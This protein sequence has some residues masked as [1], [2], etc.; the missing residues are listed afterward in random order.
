[1]IHKVSLVLDVECLPGN[2][3][4]VKDTWFRD[5]D[6]A[7]VF[8]RHHARIVI[9][10]MLHDSREEAEEALRKMLEENDRFFFLRPLIPWLKSLPKLNWK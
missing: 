6:G 4:V 5:E 3:P 1:M 2:P 9:A 8:N 10:E 7:Q